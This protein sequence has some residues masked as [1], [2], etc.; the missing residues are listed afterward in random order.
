MSKFILNK[1]LS[2]HHQFYTDGETFDHE[3]PSD[4]LKIN[5][6]SLPD[7][8]V[9][10]VYN[11]QGENRIT[12][13]YYV[14]ADWLIRNQLAIHVEPK[15][16]TAS[17][18][19]DYLGMFVK[20]LQHSDVCNH[21]AR[22]YEIKID[23]PQIEIN[24]EDDLI[25]PLLIIRYIQ[26]LKG[27]VK[28]GLRRDYVTAE[29]NLTGNIK[30]KI[31]VTKTVAKNHF[32]ANK[33]KTYCRFQEHS[34]NCV[35]NR[36][37]KKA[38]NFCIRYSNQFQLHF[39]RDAINFINPAFEKV[40]S[41][42]DL[43]ELRTMKF[44]GLYK[45]YNEALRLAKFILRRFGNNINSVSKKES[46]KVPPFWI[47]MSLLFELYVLGLLKDRFGTQV[48]YHFKSLGNELDFLLKTEDYKMVID[49]KYKPKYLRTKDNDDMRQISGY[50]RLK[51]V[52]EELG[53]L[54][55]KSIDCLIVYPEQES[56]NSNLNGINLKGN[57]IKQ[58]EGFYKVG[59]V[60]PLQ[61]K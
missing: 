45:E 9:Y 17:A 24:K 50:A 8:P 29:Q 54:Y 6:Q 52:Y 15:I 7:K 30:G 3:Q 2:E 42:V 1:G 25:T 5:F 28:K 58:Y 21:T 35:E 47:D 43:N 57:P 23:S 60:L 32:Q 34:F 49:A 40:S 4:F 46:V 56:G 61:K 16:D 38:Y 37:L 51:R 53:V 12:T 59:L 44:G 48:K 14:G 11:N 26:L 19:T 39:N 10:T 18:K 27:I 20:A 33:A 22:L 41:T 36:V 55:P 13:S 31:L